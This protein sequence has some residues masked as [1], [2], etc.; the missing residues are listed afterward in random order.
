MKP[1]K[2][3]RTRWD[4]MQIIKKHRRFQE[5][6]FLASEIAA[7]TVELGYV[8]TKFNAG[9]GMFSLEKAGWVERI[10]VHI[11]TEGPFWMPSNARAWQLTEKGREVLDFLPEE[12]PPRYA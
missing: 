12:R 11:P 8:R 1:P 4:C 6:P 5:R 9:A 2:L 10:D 3:T 7:L